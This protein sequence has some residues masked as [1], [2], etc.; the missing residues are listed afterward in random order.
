MAVQF[1]VQQ[2]HEAAREER[3]GARASLCSRRAEILATARSALEGGDDPD[4]HVLPRLYRDLAS[5]RIVDASLAF[6]VTRPDEM[7]M[8]GF[9]DGFPADVIRRCL[10]R[11]FGESICGGVAQTRRAMHVTDIQRTVDPL[12]DVVRSNGITAYVCEPLIVGDRLLGTLSFATRCSRSF[13]PADLRLFHSVTGHV[14]LARNRI[15]GS[16]SGQPVA[17]QQ[18]R[19]AA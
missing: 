16:W 5:E 3:L 1:P 12:A 17:P 15:E 13:D 7:M 6:V 8:L 14:A 10:R 9:V 4:R 18:A 11:S 2:L 19:S